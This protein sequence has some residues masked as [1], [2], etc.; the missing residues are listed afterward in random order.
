[1]I[2]EHPLDQF[3]SK[4]I[5]VTINTDNRTVSN[6]TMASEYDV[7]ETHFSWNSSHWKQIYEMSIEAAFA[8]DLTKEFLREKL[9][10]WDF[11]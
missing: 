1:L 11:N 9:N 2:S 10:Q 5:R 8:D 4:D 7:L 3:Y 6:T